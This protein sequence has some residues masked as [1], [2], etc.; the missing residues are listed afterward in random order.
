MPPGGPHDR[1]AHGTSRESLPHFI[2][3]P[4]P[5]ATGSVEKSDEACVVCGLA[6]GYIYVGPVY[7]VEEYIDEVCPWCIADGTAHA[8]L[9]AHFTDS[10]QGDVPSSIKEIVAFRTPGYNSWQAEQWFTHCNAAAAFLG[11]V[12][13]E[14][15][16]ELGPE[17]I[18]AIR[19]DTGIADDNEWEWFYRRLD[20]DGSPT[21]Y[22]F[23]CIHCGKYGGYTD[24]D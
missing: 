15:L 3:H 13:H 21:A 24:S 5:L 23:K 22:I 1:E 20:K 12:G 4:D 8:Q 18:E 2:Y 6:R 16:E 19:A 17:A 14:E 9:D 10:L 11:A 7:A